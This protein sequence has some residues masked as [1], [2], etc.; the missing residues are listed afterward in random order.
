MQFIRRGG[1]RPTWICLAIQRG[2]NMTYPPP[3]QLAQ[4]EC[5]GCPCMTAPGFAVTATTAEDHWSME[6]DLCG[7]LV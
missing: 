3:P 4:E 2:Q 7:K 5:A 1:K 6:V